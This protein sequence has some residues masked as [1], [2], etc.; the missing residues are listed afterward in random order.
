MPRFFAAAERELRVKKDKTPV[1]RKKPISGSK[2]KPQRRKAPPGP[3][4][5]FKMLAGRATKIIAYYE[6][7]N[8]G[9][10]RDELVWFLMLDLM[11]HCDRDPALGTFENAFI[12]A[13]RMYD[14][15]VKQSE[16]MVS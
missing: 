8:L 14:K 3:D 6:T 1:S 11:H 16:Y 9:S 2:F 10:E 13:S 4:G 15:L 5:Y 12:K 7:L